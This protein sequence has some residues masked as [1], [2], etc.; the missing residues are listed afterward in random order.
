M[1][2]KTP[3]ELIDEAHQAIEHALELIRNQEDGPFTMTIAL[4]EIDQQI[5]A[6]ENALS[7]WKGGLQRAKDFALKLRGQRDEAVRQRDHVIEMLQQVL[8]QA[9][10]PGSTT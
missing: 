6:I 3:Q 2:D 5:C 1:S 8:D 4:R 10:L 9:T 7:Y